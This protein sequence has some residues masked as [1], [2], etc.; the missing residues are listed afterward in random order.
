MDDYAV[1]K[2]ILLAIHTEQMAT[3]KYNNPLLIKE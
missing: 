2:G 3:K 1:S